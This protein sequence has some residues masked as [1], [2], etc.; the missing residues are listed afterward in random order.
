MATSTKSI[1]APKAPTGGVVKY[2]VTLTLTEQMLGTVPKNRDI[3][4]S[5]I[6][7]KAPE[8][9]TD[10]L[11]TVEEVEERGWTGFHRD[12][13]GGLFLFDY[14]VRGFL[15]ESIDSLRECGEIELK[16]VR[17]KI[18]RFLHVVPRR[19]PICDASGK[20]VTEPA[21]V[22]ERPLRAQTMRGERVSLAR[23]D[24]VAAGATLTFS[25]VNQWADIFTEDM[26]R[27]GLDRGEWL[28]L[29]QW[30]TGG[31]GRFTYTLERV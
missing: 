9:P 31:N 24:I 11:E 20:Q 23:S 18:D 29:G 26:I 19:I 21:G 3:Y 28:G 5:Y 1:K 27:A 22:C 17:R 25:L 30:R 4:A 2:K 6:A 7:T 10:E 12:D 13:H 8:L 14:Q 16:A 15:K